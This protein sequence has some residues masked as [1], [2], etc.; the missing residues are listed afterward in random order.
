M[1]RKGSK[2][3]RR[4][5]F[6][7]VAF[8]RANQAKRRAM[9]ESYWVQQYQEAARELNKKRQQR[10]D[11]DLIERLEK[12]L[13]IKKDDNKHLKKLLREGERVYAQAAMLLDNAEMMETLIASYQNAL[14]LMKSARRGSRASKQIRAYL[15]EI[16]TIAEMYKET[17]EARRKIKY[18]NLSDDL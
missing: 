11:D 18:A 7:R 15:D 17:K 14:I 9:Q 6:Y 2:M 8:K 5:D 16:E 13:E 4:L 10:D 1:A 12:D 3:Q